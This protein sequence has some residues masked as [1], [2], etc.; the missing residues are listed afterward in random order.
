MRTDHR[1]NAAELLIQGRSPAEIVHM[2]NVPFGVVLNQLYH[3]V[4]QGRIRRSDILFSIPAPSRQAIEQAIT[5]AEGDTRPGKIARLLKKANVEIPR[6]DLDVYLRLRDARVDLGDMYEMVRDIELR[7][8][9]A[10]R[11]ALL[12][13]YGE[14]D[15]WRKGVPLTVREDCAVMNERDAEPVASLYNYTTVMHLRIIIDKDWNVLQRILPSRL[16]ADKQQFLQ[17]LVRLNRIRNI[18]MH[19]V[20]GVMFTADDFDFVRRLRRQLLQAEEK[21]HSAAGK[22]GREP[23]CATP[24]APAASDSQTQTAA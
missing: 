12:S 17:D 15:W 23:S 5:Q 4:G 1:R 16:R 6:E 18:V 2:T 22:P 19:P 14:G 8:H 20:K 7:L 24:P 13:E 21:V 9:D 10:V 11:M 3:Q